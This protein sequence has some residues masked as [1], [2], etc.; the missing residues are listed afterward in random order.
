MSNKNNTSPLSFVT[1]AN[2]FVGKALSQK[3]LHAGHRL[4]LL[5][6]NKASFANLGDFEPYADRV[7]IIEGDLRRVADWES[8]LQNC[9]YVFNAAGEIRD[10][11]NM[12]ALNV[13]ATQDLLD[14]CTGK[15]IKHITHLSSVGVIGALRSGVVDESEPCNPADMYERTKLEAEQVIIAWQQTSNIP[16]AMLRPTII[17]GNGSKSDLIPF[18][19]SMIRRGVVVTL[20]KNAIANFIHIDDVADSCVVACEQRI[21]GAYI[22]ASPIKLREFIGIAAGEMRKS[23]VMLSV[24]PGLANTVAFGAESIFR[25]IKKRPPVSR[26]LCQA[27]ATRTHYVGTR[28]SEQTGWTPGSHK[29]GIRSTLR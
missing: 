16:V 22:I 8:A 4:K 5:T 1:G 26:R 25:L 10:E 24:P 15:N 12:V 3:L 21:D 2:G 18:W 19:F 23:P 7:T 13:D 6:R 29:E 14:A 11:A 17:Y 9:D 28:F 20:G 27:L